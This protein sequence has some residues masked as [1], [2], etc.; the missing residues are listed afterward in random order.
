LR[1]ITIPDSVTFIGEDAFS[2]C[3]SLRSITI[4]D[5]VTSIGEGAFH[6]CTSLESITIPSRVISIGEEAFCN[7]KSLDI[8]NVSEDNLYYTS[9]DGALFN[10][11]LTA[12]I[13]FPQGALL[14]EYYI[15]DG[16]TT[17]RCGAFR[18][19]ESLRNITIPDS[20]TFIGEDAFSYCKSLRSIN[21]HWTDLCKCNISEYSFYNF[22]FDNCTLY[23][24]AETDEN[25]RQHP[26][27]CKFKNIKE[28]ECNNLWHSVLRS[29]KKLF[30]L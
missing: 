9:V 12:I 18:G 8:I 5:S 4:P 29:I 7:C 27:F 1:N 10:K 30:N 2:Y 22:D 11:D 26:V 28:R 25:Y 15:P 24:P 6:C 23:I 19:C 17:L 21:L 20:V 14:K 3:K 16:V 13:K